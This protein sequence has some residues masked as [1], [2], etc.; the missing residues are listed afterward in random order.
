[1]VFD[2]LLSVSRLLVHISQNLSNLKIK[3]L[4]KSVTLF[5]KGQQS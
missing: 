4:T 5:S 2:V 1:M 3:I